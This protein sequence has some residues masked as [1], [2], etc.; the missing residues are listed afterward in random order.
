MAEKTSTLTGQET[1]THSEKMI[2]IHEQTATAIK[3]NLNEPTFQ[4]GENELLYFAL[5]KAY[6][7]IAAHQTEKE[8][9]A[10][11]LEIANQK[12]VFQNVEKDKR[13]AELVMANQELA[14]QNIEK[15]KRAA[16]LVIANQKLAF[17]NV[18]KAK[19]AKELVMANQELAFENVNKA[20]HAKEL[21]FVITQNEILNQQINHLQKIE[22]IGR[23]TAGISHDF[24]NILACMLGYN[25][26]NNDIRQDMKDEALKSEL[27][28]N[29]KQ[30][31]NAGQRAVG[32]IAKM[33]TY[34][35]QDTQHEKVMNIRHTPKVINEIVDMLRP[36]LTS[37]IRLEFDNKCHVNTSNCGNCFIRD[38]CD[39][40]IKIDADEL[41]QIITNLAVNARDAMKDNGNIITISLDKVTP[42]LNT[43]CTACAAII[44]G[45]FIE[46]G[47]SD[48]GAGIEP[49]MISRI[50]D[51]FFTTKPQG[52]GTGL[53]LSTLTGLVHSAK[54]HIIIDSN[55][56][57]PNQGTVF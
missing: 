21:N 24:N 1:L 17:E 26:M 6:E 31:A 57:Q 27:E 54:G 38:N 4:H 11:E 56:T 52:E 51:P 28:H 10:D 12:L 23:L 44:E 30:I 20:K 5:M 32:L 45:S 3:V 14:F 49:K 33:M 8:K 13:A 18:N 55:L 53:G 43:K 48:N 40:N 16:E 7:E 15:E 37:R 29:T 22:S 9:R 46:L 50:F 39:M 19:R 36:A 34:A 41:H 25:E 35:R 42:K 2:I 47:V